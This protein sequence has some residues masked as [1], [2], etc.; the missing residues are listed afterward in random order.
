MVGSVALVVNATDG[1][2]IASLLAKP[3]IVRMLGCC[4]LTEWGNSS[5][6][7]GTRQ[8]SAKM[9]CSSPVVYLCR[10]W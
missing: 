9:Q 3:S 7:S 8:N 6:E 1:S 5:S 2:W 10:K 4:P